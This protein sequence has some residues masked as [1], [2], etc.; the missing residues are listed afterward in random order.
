MV[1][2]IIGG[3]TLLPFLKKKQDAGSSG[4]LVKTREPD[5]KPDGEESEDD[6][7]AAIESC[8]AALISAIHAHDI[9]GASEALKDAFEILESMPHDENNEEKHSYDA[10]NALAA[11]GD[12]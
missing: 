9:K 1:D 4:L 8:A 11:K 7:S 6:S 2:A 12:Y 5:A 3:S 10:Q